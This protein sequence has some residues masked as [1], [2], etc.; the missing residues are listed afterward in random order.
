MSLILWLIIIL[1]F[2]IYMKSSCGKLQLLFL[3]PRVTTS[4][5]EWRKRSSHFRLG[6]WRILAL[7][8]WWVAKWEKKNFW[9][10]IDRSIEFVTKRWTTTIYLILAKTPRPIRSL[11]IIYDFKSLIRRI[12]VGVVFRVKIVKMF[13]YCSIYYTHKMLCRIL[14]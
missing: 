3:F 7:T 12:I 9:K 13:V 6:N 1:H 5:L 2:Y 10:I 4:K 11:S 8:K 14:V